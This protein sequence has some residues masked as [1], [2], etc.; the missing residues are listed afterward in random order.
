M[1]F[2]LSHPAAVLP[3]MR[4]PF[5]PPALVAGAMAPD[6]AYFIQS[7]PFRPTTSVWYEPY[8][9]ATAT[10]SLT[11]APTVALPLALALVAVYYLLRAPVAALLPARCAPAPPERPPSGAGERLRTGAWLV[12][13]ALIGIATHVAW[14][15][16]THFDGY[17][18]SRVDLLRDPVP[19]GLTVARVLQHLSTAA[20]LVAVGVHLVRRRRRT[21]TEGPAVRRRPSPAVRRGAAAALALAAGAGAVAQTG[22]PGSYFRE[23][24]A[25]YSRPVVTDN[26]TGISYPTR[27]AEVPWPEATEKIL[28][29][30]AKGAGTGLGGGLLLYGAAWHLRLLPRRESVHGR[31]ADAPGPA[32]HRPRA[33]T[34]RTRNGAQS[35]M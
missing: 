2:T 8:F 6:I 25:D 20:G 7:L 13:S 32:G 14:D 15:S 21:G 9:N 30:A 3:L 1:P 24:V 11:D 19:G 28:T 17:A 12:L 35:G 18:V 10:H 4:R 22:S 29:H 33:Q 23:E 27:T 26:G 34:Q 5:V 16:F 31:A